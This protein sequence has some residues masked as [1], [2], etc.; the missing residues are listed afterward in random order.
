MTGAGRGLGRGAA[1]ALARGGRARHAGR[2]LARTSW[3]RS[4]PEIE[5]AGGRAGVA[6][7]DV[8]DE[9]QVEAALAAADAHA[10]GPRDDPRHR[11]GPQPHR[12]GRRSATTSPTGTGSWTSTCAA[13]SSPAAPF[14]RRLLARGAGGRIVTLSSQMGVVGYP[15]RAAYCATKHA[16]NGLTKALAVEWAPHGIAVNAVAPTFVRT[17]MTEAMLADPAFAAEVAAAAADGPAREVGDV[18]AAVR[19]PRLRR[20]PPRSPGTCSRSTAAGRPGSPPPPDARGN[21]SGPIRSECPPAF[22]LS[23]PRIATS[24]LRDDALTSRSPARPPPR[25]RAARAVRR[26]RRPR[27]GA[28]RPAPPLRRRRDDRHDG[29]RA[30]R[31]RRAH[32]RRRGAA[33]PSGL[34]PVLHLQDPELADR[35]RPRR[36]VG[37]GQPYPA[38]NPNFLVDGAPFL[39]V[40]CEGDLTLAT[41]F[42]NSCIPIYQGIAR[43]VGRRAYERALD[44]LDYGNARVDGAP[45][46]RFWL[47][48]PLAIDAREQVRFL[49][50]LRRGHVPFGRR[51]V[52]DV[53][54]MLVVERGPGYVLRGKTGWVFT[55]TPEVGWWVGSV[56]RDGAAWTFALNLDITR[57]ST[58]RRAG[59]RA[60]DPD[61]ARGAA[62]CLAGR[63]A[64]VRLGAAR[65]AVGCCARAFTAGIDGTPAGRSGS[66]P[67]PAPGSLRRRHPRLSIP[68]WKDRRSTGYGLRRPGFALHC[69]GGWLQIGRAL[70]RL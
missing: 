7:A 12:P 30:A 53:R 56:E 69:G 29:R 62:G 1:L 65:S 3:R 13:R 21:G 2:P 44:A 38:P 68:R 54:D 42:A 34:P 58:P 57:P 22:V 14:G 67:G 25:P 43:A 17:P 6:V 47:E 70:Q 5:A 24:L 27:R 48:G 31:T 10:A 50:R 15:G 66:G 61:R 55:T 28:A 8:A 63:A 4:R 35:D 19:L 37:G 45:V 32:R 26:A 46:D 23:G 41:A 51:A 18:A 52:A 33:Q 60:R 9:A 20:A 11:G 59:H 39:P 36:R 64:P 49:D 40:A 16:V